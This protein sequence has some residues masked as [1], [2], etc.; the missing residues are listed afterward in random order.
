MRGGPNKPT[1]ACTIAVNFKQTYWSRIAPGPGGP[2]LCGDED[3][4]TKFR[5][6]LSPTL[7]ERKPQR[8]TLAEVAEQAAHHVTLEEEARVM[9]RG[10]WTLIYMQSV[11]RLLSY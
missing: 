2:R 9:E 10:V 4:H 6:S 1:G 8:C 7:E 5:K 3:F 11:A